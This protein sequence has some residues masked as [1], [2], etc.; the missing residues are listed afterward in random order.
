MTAKCV[1]HRASEL[2]PS[3]MI[4]RLEHLQ[5]SLISDV[6]GRWSGAVGLA[7][8]AGLQRG[9]VVAGPAFTVRTRPGDNLVV[10]KAMDIARPGEII[11]VAAGGHVDRAIIG[12][13]MGQYAAKRQIAALVIDGAVRD[14][15]SLDELSPPVFAAGLSQLGPYKDGPGELR[16]PVSVGGVVVHDGD[17]VV[18]DEDGI[19]VIPRAGAEEVIHAA[20]AKRAAEL[21]E[22]RDI[23]AGTWDR[24]WV[25]EL[26]VAR[27]GQPDRIGGAPGS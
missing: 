19:T 1:L 12:G 24:K 13:L 2:P 8:I 4:S 25:D 17:L 3:E 22:S 18:G 20:E 26:L 6:F 23:S 9:Q 21:A 27:H 10:H 15:S 11:V 14:R 7:P 16:G 5:T